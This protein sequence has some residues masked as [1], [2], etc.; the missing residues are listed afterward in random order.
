MKR[1][2]PHGKKKRVYNFLSPSSQSQPKQKQRHVTKAGRKVERLFADHTLFTTPGASIYDSAAHFPHNGDKRTDR[3]LRRDVSKSD[4]WKPTFIENHFKMK[5]ELKKL[6]PTDRS[7][8][9]YL[10][11]A[12]NRV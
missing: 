3:T 7:I 10:L 1:G 11:Q 2:R 6:F 12:K 9:V 4:E 5:S 8:Y